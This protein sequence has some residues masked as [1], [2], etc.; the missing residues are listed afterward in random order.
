MA[1]PEG[2][3][4]FPVLSEEEKE[5]LTQRIQTDEAR[6]AER[7][8]QVATEE[9]GAWLKDFAARHRFHAE[10]GYGVGE[11]EGAD[12]ENV[13]LV[14]DFI[15]LALDHAEQT[16]ANTR[17]PDT[18]FPTHEVEIA[19]DDTVVVANRM[20]GQGV[21]YRLYPPEDD[22]AAIRPRVDM[23]ELIEAAR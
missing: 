13:E 3:P 18:Y 22:P 4:N 17:K 16:G 12:S 11:Y 8:Q 1:T 23:A 14:L 2:K 7:R 20:R 5:R 19:I 6:R 10:S 9:Y 21:M 15:E